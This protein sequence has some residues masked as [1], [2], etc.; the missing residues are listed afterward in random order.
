MAA[1]DGVIAALRA[2]QKGHLQEPTKP[3]YS[4]L[5]FAAAA[6]NALSVFMGLCGGADAS[7][8]GT[9]A[10]RAG[11]LPLLEA[12]LSK[13]EAEAANRGVDLDPVEIG[14][15]NDMIGKLRALVARADAAAAE[16]IAEEEARAAPARGKAKAGKASSKSKGGKAAKASA[17]SAA[18]Q[19]PTASPAVDAA[20]ADAEPPPPPAAVLPAAA[21]PP[22][23][24]PAL[25]P[26]LLDAM[27][28]LPPPSAAQSPPAS[29]VLPSSARYVDT[30][31]G[32]CAICLDAPAVLRTTCC[33]KQ[34]PVYCEPCAALLAGV[35]RCALCGVDAAEA[36]AAAR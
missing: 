29:A 31:D 11:A 21:P 20:S 6:A 30:S 24:L 10:Y 28:R 32:T 34:G 35:T 22:P 1:V 2:V 17:A 16:L 8:P 36:G 25:P 9:Y 12:A 14:I 3:D 19:Q 15:T 13:A 33:A 5:S 7:A 4:C 26:W 27:Q 18:K 23:A